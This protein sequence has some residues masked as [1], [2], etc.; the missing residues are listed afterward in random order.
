MPLKRAQ[1]APEFLDNNKE[2]ED[3]ILNLFN[4]YMLFIPANLHISTWDTHAK[5][6]M[7]VCMHIVSHMIDI[8]HALLRT[9]MVTRGVVSKARRVNNS[10]FTPETFFLTFS[11]PLPHPSTVSLKILLN[12]GSKLLFFF[13]KGNKTL[14]SLP[15]STTWS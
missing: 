11:M 1:R 14:S 15:P 10:L 6:H 3:I 7:H 8:L 9:P 2:K 12:F 13:S 4:K 5:I